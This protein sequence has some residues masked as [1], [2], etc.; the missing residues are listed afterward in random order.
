MKKE[1]RVRRRNRIRAKISGTSVCPRLAVYK[2][3]RFISAQIIDD[4]TGTTLGASHSKTMKGK[5]LM[6]KATAVGKDIATLAG[7]KK[8]TKVVFDRGGFSYT[9]AIKAVAEGARSGGLIF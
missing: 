7:T 8:I 3:N 5:N 4:V 6:E 2:S 9:G 1:Q